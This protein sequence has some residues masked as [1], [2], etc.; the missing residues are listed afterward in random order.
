MGSVSCIIEQSKDKIEAQ[1]LTNQQAH[2]WQRRWRSGDRAGGLALRDGPTLLGEGAFRKVYKETRTVYITPS[3]KVCAVKKLDNFNKE[4][5]QEVET[6]MKLN[7]KYI[8]KCYGH[9]YEDNGRRLCIVMEYADKG[10]F[11]EVVTKAA[12]NP[13]SLRFKEFNIWRCLRHL[14]LALDYLHTLPQPI[15][16]RDLKPDN[17]LGWTD[18]ADNCIVLKLADFGLVKL[19]EDAAQGD[20]YAQTLCGTPSYMAPEVWVN[21]KGY[22]FSADIWSLGCI[23][24]FICNKGKHL[25]SMAR[26]IPELVQKMQRGLPQGAIQGYSSDLVRLVGRMIHPDHHKRPS[27]KDIRAECTYARTDEH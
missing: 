21:Y 1:R 14:S 7:H 26:T 6:L 17:I 22:T 13:G 20:F 12:Q 15:L 11:T 16:H 5:V 19:L 9:H 2:G 3:T 10:T 23:I 8:I 4:A 18:P 27:A 25:F 24:A